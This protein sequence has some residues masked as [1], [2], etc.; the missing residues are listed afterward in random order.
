MWKKITEAVN[1]KND[2]AI[3][4]EEFKTGMRIMKQI[5]NPEFV[6]Y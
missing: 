4:F 1:T 2:E 5:T 3:D 6:A